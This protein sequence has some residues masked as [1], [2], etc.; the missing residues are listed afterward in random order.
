MTCIAGFVEGDTVWMGADSAGVSNG[1]YGL[2]VRSDG[3]LFKNAAML[4]GFTTSFRMGQ[5]LRHALTIPDHDPRVPIEKYMSTTFMNAVRDCLKSHGWARKQNESEVGGTFLVGYRGRL[6]VIYDDYQVGEPADGIEAVGCGYHIAKG[7]LFASQKK[8]RDR[9]LT[10]L[11]A[12][13][14][15]SAGVRGPFHIETLRPR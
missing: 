15:Y 8:G 13:E 11:R 12:A 14:A 1:D 5:L 3:K 4:F 6:F 9:I 10:A 7:A 2:T